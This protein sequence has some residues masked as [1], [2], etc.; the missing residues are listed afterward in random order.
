MSALA[1]RTTPPTA[2]FDISL[3]APALLKESDSQ[4]RLSQLDRAAVW[5]AL[6]SAPDSLP[7]PPGCSD[8][9]LKR[10]VRVGILLAESLSDCFRSEEMRDDEAGR[11]EEDSSTSDVP[12]GLDGP[13]Y[14]AWAASE[15][16]PS[17]TSSPE[18][19]GGPFPASMPEG[20]SSDERS[21]RSFWSLP[22]A[23]DDEA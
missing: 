5:E 11:S 2:L 12:C 17:S 7:S 4:L 6:G 8:A 19:P 21:W 3:Y 22:M 13:S 1:V 10:I 9:A 14:D 18:A 15:V 20:T 23:C 16:T